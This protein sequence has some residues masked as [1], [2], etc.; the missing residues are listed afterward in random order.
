MSIKSIRLTLALAIFLPIAVNAQKSSIHDQPDAK[1]R[2]A[3]SLF[4][5]EQYGPAMNLFDRVIELINNPHDEVSASSLFYSG[6]CAAELQN[7]SAETKL[8]EFVERHSNHP[9]QNLARFNLGKIKYSE[10]KFREAENWFSIVE[11]AQLDS[12]LHDELFFK[13]GHSHFHANKYPEALRWLGRVNN[14]RSRFYAAANYFSAHI[15]YEQN[16]LAVALELFQKIQ[17]DPSVGQL[18][19]YYISHIFYLQNEYEKLIEFAIPLI[20]QTDN[21]RNSEIS[22]LVG[23]AFFNRGEYD[24]AIPFFETF[25]S[26]EPNR[27]SPD[28]R[29]QLGFAHFMTRNFERAIGQFERLITANDAMAQNAHF[30]LGAAY[31]ETGQKRFARNA[32]LSAHQNSHDPK[33]TQ[34]ALF[35]FAKLSHELSIDSYNDALNSFQTYINLYPTSSRVNQAFAHL[36]SIYLSTRNFRDALDYIQRTPVNTPEMRRAFQRI[37]YYRGVELFNGGDLSGA[38]AMFDKSNTQP[39][40]A[41]YLALATFWKG[42]AQYRL[43]RHDDAITTMQRFL[44]SPG[45]FSLPEFNRANYTV[46]YAH[47]NNRNFAAA[48]QAFRRFTNVSG[49]PQPLVNDATLRIGDSQFMLKDFSSAIEAYNRVIRNGGTGADYATLQKGLAQGAINQFNP[50]ISTLQGLITSFPNSRHI[51]NALYEIAN[52]H[53]TLDNSPQALAFFSRVIN[54]HPNSQFVKSAMLKSGLIHFNN[55]QDQQALAMFKEVINKYPGSPE[56]HEAL[57]V[58]RNIYLDLNQV[59]RFVE[60]SRGLN[61]AN[62]SIAQQDSLTYM[63]AENRFMQNDCTSAIAGFNSYLQRFRSGIFVINASFYLAECQF[64]AGNLE[65]ALRNYNEVISRPKSQFTENALLRAGQI[66]FNRNNNDAAL[67][68]YRRL[69]D[70]ADR[71]ENQ[72]IAMQ[73]QMRSLFRLKRYQESINVAD[74]IIT[75]QRVSADA[76]QEAQFFK[77]KSALELNQHSIAQTSLQNAITISGNERAAE[78]MFLLAYIQH[79]QGNFKRSEELIFQFSNQMSSHDYWLARSFILLADNYTAIGN[80]FQAKSTLQSIIDNYKGDDLRQEARQ[81]LDAII[82]KERQGNQRGSSPVEINLDRNRF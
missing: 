55:N 52:S 35:I 47:F 28:D 31:L 62:I 71:P 67:E 69:E 70:A 39:Q 56:S 49:E 26:M 6:I 25:F 43:G 61:F 78:A 60:F 16:N 75:N 41:S 68:L 46:G 79:I 58:M 4:Y 37:A 57:N 50:K 24:K 42:E 63:A 77:G 74:R 82:E 81:K 12:R 21:P 59:D 54:Q 48:I 33:I 34:D 13:R 30:H 18:V 53:L 66:E 64:R 80:L 36:A 14:P 11:P 1:Y 72:I 32:F 38:I 15:H 76:R 7:P 2:Q 8:I 27:I 9:G 65:E 22:K 3:L 19:P 44:T 17:N 10:R 51:A 73:G 20:R 23:D 5:N 45:A 29:F 40:V